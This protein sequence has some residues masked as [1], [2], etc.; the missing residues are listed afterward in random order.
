MSATTH[1]HTL[2]SVA[3]ITGRGLF[4]GEA[5]T[6]RICPAEPNT[7]VVFVRTDLPDAGPIP[8]HV[9]NVVERPR[10]TALEQGE[11]SVEMVEHCLSALAGLGVDNARIEVDAT[12]MP[13]G[14]GSASPYVNAMLGVGLEEQSASRDPITVTEPITIRENDAMIAAYPN[15]GS[16]LDLLY[17]LE[18]DHSR[19]IERQLHAFTL[20]SKAYVEKIAPARTFALLEEAK[21]M[22]ERGM[23]PHLTPKDMLVIGEQGPVENA[24]RFDDEPVRHKLLDLIGDLALAGRPINARVVACRSGHSL[25][26]QMAKAILEQDRR[27]E[28]HALAQPAMDTKQVLHLLPHRYPMVLVDR[29]LEID[30]DSRAVGIK[31]VSINE[32]FFQ[33]HYP[34]SPIMPGVLIVEAMSQLAGLMLSQKLERAGKIAILLSLDHVKLRKP[35]TPGDQL[36]M[37]TEALRATSRFGD[38]ACRAFVDGQLVAQANVKF[39]MVDAEQE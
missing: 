11:A 36:V 25:N 31:N 33:G 32:P 38:V 23:F 26:Q 24:L 8:A 20:D 37:E 22:Q 21:A 1:Q 2:A 6:A 28:Q 9:D 34:G 12:E 19:V 39:M 35:V 13:A 4:S 29:V 7:G 18:Y 3:T 30:G 27:N 15:N 10:R 5:S 17:D 14:D 16:G